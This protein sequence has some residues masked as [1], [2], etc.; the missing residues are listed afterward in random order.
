MDGSEICFLEG[1]LGLKGNADVGE[2]GDVVEK[3][4]VEICGESGERL[5]L[6]RV[7]GIVGGEHAGGGG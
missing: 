7:A 2:I 5:K 6:R 1:E 4:G 3:G